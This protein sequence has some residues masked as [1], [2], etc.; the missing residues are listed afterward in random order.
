MVER[1]RNPNSRYR[2]RV[3]RDRTEVLA[4]QLKN[5]PIVNERRERFGKFGRKGA[6]QRHG[7]SAKVK[8]NSPKPETAFTSDVKPNSPK[9]YQEQYQ[10]NIGENAS[11]Y[12]STSSLESETNE[13]CMPSESTNPTPQINWNG[14]AEWLGK[15]TKRDKVDCWNEILENLNRIEHELGASPEEAAMVLDRFL[16]II[17]R[18]F[19][20]TP[21]FELL[22]DREKKSRGKH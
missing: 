10:S 8:K 5:Q 3:I 11:R 18:S 14:W 4:T 20:D 1:V 22:L 15:K 9:Q 12:L 6:K 17:R 7:T 16:K 21:S 2:Y 19:P 13:T